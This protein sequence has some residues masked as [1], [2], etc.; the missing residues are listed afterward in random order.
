MNNAN[1]AAP[2]SAD[3]LAQ[4]GSAEGSTSSQLIESFNPATGAKIGDVPVTPLNQLPDIMSRARAA[5]VGWERAGLQHRLKMLAKFKGIF[6]VNRQRLMDCL[7]AEQG[8]TAIEAF[9][10]E[11]WPCIELINYYLQ[12]ATKILA[13]KPMYQPFLIPT[14]YQQVERRPHGVVFVI[15][16][17][18]FPLVLANAPIVAALA[19]GNTI[20]FKPSEF[21]AQTGQLFVE[22]LWEAGIPRDV[23]QIVHGTGAVAAAVIDHKPNKISFTGSVAT[24]RKVAVAAGAHLIPVT[25]ELGGKDAAIVLDDADLDWTAKG[26]V[27]SGMINAGQICQS[28]ERVFVHESIAAALTEKMTQQ[29]QRHMVVGA[30]DDPTAT[31]G[32]ITTQ[33]QLN[34][35]QDHVQD[36]INQGAKVVFGGKAKVD[37]ATNGRGRFY[38]PTLI[39][40]VTPTMRVAKDETFGPILALTTFATDAE[41]IQ[42]H[43]ETTFGLIGSIWTRDR[44]R[45]LGLAR[46]LKA[47]HV[48]LNDHFFSC[49]LPAM[50]WGG[51][52][53]SGYGR[54]RGAEGLLEMTTT[55]GISYNL[56]NFPSH[57]HLAWYPYTREKRAL[58][59]RFITF[60]HAPTWRERLAALFT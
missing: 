42:R 7:V 18:N 45:G 41:V 33:A 17:W 36:A 9:T 44:Q 57:E 23:L 28:V 58:L 19:A 8:K 47:G 30:G 50:P 56:L 24:G 13:P 4:Q 55:Q 3:Q 48:G 14:R 43:N 2:S 20:I 39:T 10:L 15:T 34:I 51:V 22:L 40:A 32:A 54:T 49:N 1:V 35:I 31:V 25:L 52:G 16:P 37:G 46:Q 29:L 53:E 12:H 59:E 21:T 5:Q 26:I 38:E 60:N 11:F 6:F 27:W